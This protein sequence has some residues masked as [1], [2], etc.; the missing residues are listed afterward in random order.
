MYLSSK[1]RY[2]LAFPKVLLSV[3]S[4]IFFCYIAAAQSQRQR[5]SQDAQNR[6]PEV[7]SQWRS[8]LDQLSSE[9]NAIPQDEG[10]SYA[11]AEVGD[12]YW[13]IDNAVSADLFSSAMDA[14]LSSRTK[15]KDAKDPAVSVILALAS[16]R[17]TPLAKSLIDRLNKESTKESNASDPSGSESETAAADV[18]KSDA[19]HAAELLKAN[20]SSGPSMGSAWL[21]FQIAQTDPGA[22]ESVYQAYLG[23]FGASPNRSLD[24]LLWLAGYPFGYGEAYGGANDPFHFVGFSGLRI[25]GL[26][27][28]PLLASVFL[29][30]ALQV[31]YSTLQQAAGSPE[32][33]RDL[34]SGLTLF[35][36]SYCLPEVQRYR[37]QAL[38][39]WYSLNQMAL[40]GTSPSRQEG[41]TARLKE[42]LQ[43][44][45]AAANYSSPEDY[46]HQQA[47]N[48]LDRAES[49]P[50]GCERDRAYA[51]FALGSSY[52]KGFRRSLEIAKKIND[53]SI[54][55][56]VTQY[57]YYDISARA[58][59]AGNL[60][61]GERYARLVVAEDLRSLLYL[62]MARV[63]L[64]RKDLPLTSAVLRSAEA[65]T[66]GI[67]DPG[68]KVSVLLAAAEIYASFDP[69]E[70]ALKLMGAV[71]TINGLHH[72]YGDPISVSRKVNMSCSGSPNSWYGSFEQA[73]RSSLFNILPLLAAKNV[74][75]ALT[76]AYSLQEPVTRVRALA[77]IARARLTPRPATKLKV[78]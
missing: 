27:P 59:D 9:A 30:L 72:Y 37:P 45:S 34:L 13:L 62:R 65:S 75:E 31:V 26:T 32:A 42:I 25:K 57:I 41:V 54:A 47:E 55:D 69:P 38:P 52:A 53:E 16:K 15:K 46:A 58:L 70:A 11:L 64:R 73:G 20:A 43:S 71:K 8:L 10:R 60:K 18:I 63:A 48:A 61:T 19:K 24:H 49:L 40:N 51:Q 76:I 74:E 12:A 3:L 6:R 36:T 29:D 28:K 1:D 39:E 22:A 7:L 33:E 4:V 14:A 56:S 66:L 78:A 5:A 21:I 23:H 44:R 35:V 77:S 67:S 2:R 68:I 50:D 17:S